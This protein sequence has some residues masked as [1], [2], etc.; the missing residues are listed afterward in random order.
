MNRQG[1]GYG[2]IQFRLAVLLLFYSLIYTPI[3]INIGDVLGVDVGAIWD[4]V[5]GHSSNIY[6]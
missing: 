3:G 5:I 2:K 6:K 4:I 1:G